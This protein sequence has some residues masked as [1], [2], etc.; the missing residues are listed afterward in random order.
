MNLEFFEGDLHQ[1]YVHSGETGRAALFLHGFMGTPINW[2]TIAEAFA[3]EGWTVSVPLLPGFG[4]DAKK[5]KSVSWRDWV[6]AAQDIWI[7]LRN[8]YDYCLLAGHSMGGAIAINLTVQHPPDQ[9]VLT[10]PFWHLNIPA[11]QK[12]LLP[13]GKHIIKDFAVFEDTNF[14]APEVRAQFERISP[15]IDLDDPTVREY[16]RTNITIP[17]GAIDQLNRLGKH[18]IQL[19]NKV[20]IATLVFQGKNDTTVFPHHTQQLV[21][22]MSNA[23]LVML[24]AEHDLPQDDAPPHQIVRDAM[25][26][27]VSEGVVSF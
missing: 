12:H 16:I 10:A 15:G 20:D 27:F 3:A 17:L 18:T 22:Q 19:A 24:D 1:P 14:E 13:I 5:L 7:K 21:K 26:E 11:W 2:R 6:K 25:L 4:A 9:M 8:Q 23:T